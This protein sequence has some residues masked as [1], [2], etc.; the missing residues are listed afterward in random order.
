M[1]YKEALDLCNNWIIPEHKEKDKETIY[2]IFE[3][4]ME[5]NLQASCITS[6]FRHAYFGT[7]YDTGL[8]ITFDTNIRYQTE[9]LNLH[10]K[11]IWKYMIAPDM[12][13]MEVKVN[14]RIP[15]RL[16]ELIAQYNLP[17]IRVSKYCQWLEVSSKVP[18]SVYTLA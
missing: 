2:E 3:M 5:W 12:V 7:D 11:E 16:T 9:N 8:R 15:Y 6:Y 10:E 1:R 14:E 18:R 4:L 13:I 17:L